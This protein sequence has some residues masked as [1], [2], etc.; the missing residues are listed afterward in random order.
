MK[1]LFVLAFTL[2]VC[3][4][5]SFS[6]ETTYPK[7]GY[8]NLK[9]LLN[10]QPSIPFVFQIEKRTK[11][12]IRMTGGNDYKVHSEVDSISKK[13]IKNE[14]YAISTG[15]TL[16]LNCYPLGYQTWY[17]QALSTGKY[18]AF[19]AGYSTAEG[20]E[21]NMGGPFAGASAATER[22]LYLLDTTSGKVVIYDQEKF[23]EFL[24]EY[25]DLKS[26]FRN[27]TYMG[28]STLIKYI[29]LINAR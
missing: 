18:I 5:N 22:F 14:I 25:P 20:R 28:T 2:I 29:K 13:K 3:Y 1:K 7:G 19:K 4:E 24:D 11:G 9:E 21:A 26:Q 17:T 10:K 23:S 8:M 27:E 6:Q 15:D 16:F 12:D